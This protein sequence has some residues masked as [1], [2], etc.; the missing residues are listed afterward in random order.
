MDFELQPTL[1]GKRL[2]LRPLK[3]TDFDELFTAASDPLIWE[4]H[5]VKD[6]C[7]EN[8]FRK[9]FQ[10]RWILVER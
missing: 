8:G 9:F 3:P 10:S 6:R 7:G 2:E 5:P 4:Q 1:T